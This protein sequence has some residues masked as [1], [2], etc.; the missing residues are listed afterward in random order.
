MRYVHSET[1]GRGE[2][3][4]PVLYRPKLGASAGPEDTQRISQVIPSAAATLLVLS[5]L[6]VGQGF[7]ESSVW[8]SNRARFGH[9]KGGFSTARLCKGKLFPILEPHNLVC[10]G[11]T[12]SPISAGWGDWN[13]EGRGTGQAWGKVG[14]VVPQSHT[15][16][17][18]L[19]S[20]NL[21]RAETLRIGKMGMPG[22]QRVGLVDLL[23]W[24]GTSQVQAKV[25]KM[26]TTLNP[27]NSVTD[28]CEY[29]QTSPPW[30][31]QLNSQLVI[32]SAG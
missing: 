20:S 29:T 17:S 21:I 28:M 19:D 5:H 1:P 6:F 30:P 9:V 24:G 18:F 3:C 23:W 12:K 7:R 15:T 13:W 22:A 4:S 8:G 25:V 31:R 32:T 27:H 26:A 11:L 14:R 2:W 16:Q 10:P